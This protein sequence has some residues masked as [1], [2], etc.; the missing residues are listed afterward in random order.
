MGKGYF[1]QPFK[2]NIAASSDSLLQRLDIQSDLVC[3]SC[4]N[5]SIVRLA[6]MATAKVA[7]KETLLGTELEPDLSIQS[8]A[9]FERNARTDDETGESYMTEDDF[10][11]AIA[12]STENYVR[13]IP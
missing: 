4:I 2:T 9:N 11:N 3:L 12:P 10:V 13:I 5:I 6:K 7:I 1:L 8:K